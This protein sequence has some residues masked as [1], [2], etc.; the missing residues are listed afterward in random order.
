MKL[1]YYNIFI[2]KSENVFLMANTFTGAVFE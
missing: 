1:S 2:K